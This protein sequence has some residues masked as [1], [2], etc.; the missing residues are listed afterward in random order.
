MAA[1]KEL[2]KKLEELENKL[3]AHD[4]TIE[5]IFKILDVLMRSPKRKNPQIGFIP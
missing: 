4:Y 5:E 1:Q 2:S 3:I